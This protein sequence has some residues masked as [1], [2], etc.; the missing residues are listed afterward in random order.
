MA[1]TLGQSLPFIHP[2]L[3]GV[4]LAGGLVPILIHLINLRR[5][6]R[7]EWAAMTFLLSARR[8]SAKRMWMEHWL[9]LMVR[10]ALVVLLGLAIARPFVPWSTLFSLGGTRAHH[11]LLLDNSLSMNARGTGDESRFAA[12][13]RL[14]DRL[15][16]SFPSADAVSLVTLAEPAEAVIG[17]AAYDRRVVRER[18]GALGAT[19]RAVD[20]AGGLE[21]AREIVG[22]SEVPAANRFLYVVSDF[23][24]RVWTGDRPAAGIKTPNDATARSGAGPP[25]AALA[26]PG[27]AP[28]A[29]VSALR[30]AAEPLGD[31]A[32]NLAL[33]RAVAAGGGSD[34]AA[35]SR[36]A[37]ESVLVAPGLPV[38]FVAE[39]ANFSPAPLR[40]AGL[41]VR[42]DGR[43]L[44]QEPL[45]AVAPWSTASA[46]F[47]LEFSRTGS[48][49][50]Q[51]ELAGVGRD[52]LPD[53]DG[54]WYSIDVRD[55][56][57]VLLVDGRPST[58]VAEGQANF[59]AAALGG[60]IAEGLLPGAGPNGASSAGE[61]VYVEPKIVNAADLEAEV[62]DSYDVVGLCNV[63][64][65]TAAQWQRLR[66]YVAVGHG[67]LIF[68][69]DRLDVEHY[70]RFAYDEGRGVLPVKLRPAIAAG[71][72]TAGGSNG[73][74]A[75][76]AAADAPGLGLRLAERIHPIVA[77]FAGYADSG[78]F[79]ARTQ[80]YLPV[81]PDRRGGDVVMLYTNGEPAL[82][83]SAFRAGKVVLCTTT[84]NM[85]WTNLPAKGDYVSLM[86]SV[87]AHV[88]PR[89]GDQR[90]LLVGE[91]LHDPLTPV[92]SV[93]ALR[94]TTA[95]GRTV[96]P[97]LAP[98]GDGLALTFG[99]LERAGA[100]TI[101][102]GSEARAV[103]VNLDA[104]GSDL[105]VADDA[106]L[107]GAIALPA[108]IVGAAELE[109]TEPAA[110][111]S[112]ELAAVGFLSVLALLV[113]EMWLAMVFGRERG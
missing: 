21:R 70:N 39:V 81:E 13:Q 27:S 86:L 90:N 105:E 93:R 50:V 34:N 68:A 47:S 20:V 98:H 108:R 69:G 59:L 103:A 2:A 6:R 91:T 30:R 3:V 29:A 101:S 4:A 40:G 7:V 22:G 67:L 58:A 71:S 94:V 52:A 49:L 18:L 42:R 106:A 92:E 31:P 1:G 76:T 24:R 61:P 110:A 104:A 44:R 56:L 33:V 43:I 38:R 79:L 82:I 72:T 88:A 25:P 45:P 74:A 60:K 64:R 36:L 113:L 11:V 77:E 35:A 62:L 57:L 53:D 10:V 15:L 19:Q 28:T 8:R 12:A 51:I 65:L 32:Q 73:A 95:E 83:A 17:H 84:A 96:E 26:S 99:P 112:T 102:V 55:R 63:E 85:D 14:A 48:H 87:V 107:R 97:R 109:S 5:Y 46:A 54:R 41:Q 80:R 75:A 66:E 9:L 37:P 16:T 111:R 89:H 23:R 100:Y 78:L